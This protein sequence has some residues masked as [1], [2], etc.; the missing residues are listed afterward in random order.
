MKNKM[1]IDIRKLKEGSEYEFEKFYNLYI[2]RIYTIIYRVVGNM[3]DAEDIAMDV[4]MKVYDKINTFRGDA[5]LSSWVYRIAYNHGISFLRKGKKT[6]A[7][8]SVS[9]SYEDKHIQC[10]EKRE[11]SDLVRSK[12]MELPEK[13]RTAL[14][15]YHFNDLSYEEIAYT[16]GMK[17]G[18]VKTYI[19][20]GREKLKALVGEL[21]EGV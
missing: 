1:E 6:T 2:N 20:R 3:A 9:H 12:L 21:P 17:M 18:T 19:H 5:K 8:E 14:T 16:M 15:L 11:I 10:L 13:Y 7:L 4:M